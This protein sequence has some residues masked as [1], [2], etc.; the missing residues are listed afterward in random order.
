[1]FGVEET[2]LPIWRIRAPDKKGIDEL[3]SF[4]PQDRTAWR[5]ESATGWLLTVGKIARAAV[6]A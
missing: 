6:V 4:I 1:V 3:A 5:V 2:R